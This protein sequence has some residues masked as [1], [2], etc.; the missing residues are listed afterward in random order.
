MANDILGHMDRL[1][2]SATEQGLE[3]D[4]F[5]VR[6]ED[7]AVI[8]EVHGEDLM[9]DAAHVSANAYKGIPVQFAALTDSQIV[10]LVDRLGHSVE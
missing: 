3:P 1:L 7:W 6:E 10:G 8:A 2:S 9:P 4:H 5:L